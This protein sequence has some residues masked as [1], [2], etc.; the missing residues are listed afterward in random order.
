M[1][2]LPFRLT[3]RRNWLFAVLLLGVLL[4]LIAIPFSMNNEADAVSRVWKASD[5]A[6]HPQG[7]IAGVWGP[8]HPYLL[9]LVLLVF[10]DRVIAPILLEITFS[11]LTA[12]PL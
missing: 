11:V 1:Q 8:L 10:H 3:S 2:I 6:R 4:R 12:I 5:W 7:I 9:G